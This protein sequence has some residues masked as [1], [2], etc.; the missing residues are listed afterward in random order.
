[1]C[2]LI[3]GPPYYKRV[4]KKSCDDATCWLISHAPPRKRRSYGAENSSTAS[5]VRTLPDT[6]ARLHYELSLHITLGAS[7]MAAKGYAAQEVEHAYTRARELC[8][9]VGET[10]QLFSVLRGGHDP[11]RSPETVCPCDA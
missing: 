7:L 8:H 9:Q 6:P 5:L 10:P 3:A 2:R 4:F 11:R 1:M